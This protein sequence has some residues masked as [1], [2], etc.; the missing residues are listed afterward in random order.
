MIA[1]VWS[2]FRVSGSSIAIVA[3]GPKPGN[4][5]T[6]VPRI[7]PTK[8]QNK[9]MGVNATEKPRRRLPSASML[10]DGRVKIPR[11]FSAMTHRERPQK[12]DGM[13]EPNQGQRLWRAKP[14]VDPKQ[15]SEIL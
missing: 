8:H 5:P 3:A 4:T 15:Q 6:T 13:P 10:N 9:L 7:T 1:V 12:S 14:D 2:I 11:T